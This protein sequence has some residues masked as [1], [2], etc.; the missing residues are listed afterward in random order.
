[1]NDVPYT[2]TQLLA[3]SNVAMASIL[4]ILAFSLLGYTLTYNFRSQVARGYAILL[5]CVMV[6][7]ASDVALN[8]VV[9]VE[10]PSAWLR[11]QGLGIARLLGGRDL[12]TDRSEFF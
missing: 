8:R 1:M 6:T 9:G 7:F 12:G 11:F 3:A 4:V 5:A 10:S 2:V